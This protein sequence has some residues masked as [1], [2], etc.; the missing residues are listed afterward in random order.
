MVHST[1]PGPGT[2]HPPARVTA[3]HGTI[4]TMTSPTSPIP[5]EALQA[6]TKTFIIAHDRDDD[7][8]LAQALVYNAGRLAWRM[9]EAGLTTEYKTSVSDVVT[10]ADNAAEQFIAETLHTLRPED[11]LLGE[12]GTSASSHSGRTWVIDPVDGTYNFTTGS[13]YWCSA[14]SLVEG[15]PD[16]PDLIHFGAVHRP[17]MGYT[18]FG[19]ADFPTSLDGRPVGRLD[20]GGRNLAPAATCLGGYLHP[21]DIADP[22]VNEVYTSVVREFA[23]VRWNG[24][25]SVDL[26]NVSQGNNGCWMQHSV[27]P[28]DLLPGRA[29]VEGA[30]GQVKRV[31]AGGKL[32]SV[33]GTPASVGRV[34]EILRSAGDGS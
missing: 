19:G 4:G 13:D 23:T 21:T 26:G 7:A 24:S 8:A 2:P 9:R 3:C 10:A 29:L 22:T 28:W 30:G 32:W 11:G 15:D 27:L 33:A 14:L 18:W 5:A 12:E 6:I 31:T 16:D 17:A 20:D 34:V 25:A 1:A